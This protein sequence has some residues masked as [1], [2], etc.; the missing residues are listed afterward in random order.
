V[1]VHHRVTEIG[2]TIEALRALAH[3]DGDAGDGAPVDKVRVMLREPVIVVAARLLPAAIGAETFFATNVA[4]A[5]S[6]PVRSRPLRNWLRRWNG[7]WV[8]FYAI[9]PVTDAKTTSHF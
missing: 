7:T 8:G 9:I 1:D 2:V 4:A 6:S 5:A 3:D